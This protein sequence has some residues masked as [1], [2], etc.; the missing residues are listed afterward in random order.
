M[1]PTADATLR[2]HA[3][4]EYAD[5]L[6][7]LARLDDR[8]R[9]PRWRLSPWAVVDLP[10][11]RHAVRRHGR[12]RRS[13]SAPGGSWRSP[14]PRS[15]PTARCCCSA[16]PAPPRRG[17]P[18][19]SRRPIS[20]DSTLLVQGTAGTP[21]EA[22]RYGWNYARLLA[23]G[24]S[25]GALV[26]APGDAGDG[27]RRDRPGR[28]ADPHPVRRAG[29]ADHDPVGEDAADP[30]ARR[31]GPGACRGFN[32]IATANDRDRGVNEL[33]SALRRRFNTVVLPLPASAEEEVEIV[34][35][36]VDALGRRRS[37]CPTCRR[38]WRRS[39][40]WSRSSASCAPASPTDGRTKLK[41]PVG[42]AVHRRGDLG[43]H[44]RARAGRPLR[45]RRAAARRRRGG[46]RRR[47][48][49]GPGRRTGSSGRSTSRRSCASATAGRDLYRA[50]RDAS[51]MTRRT[52]FGD[53]PPRAR[54]ARSLRARAGASYAA[55]RGPDR[56]AARGRPAARAGRRRRTWSR[57]SRCSPTRR[58]ARAAPRSGRSPCSRPSGRRSAGR[59]SAG[60]PSRFMR[61]ARRRAS[62]P[63]TRARATSRAGG[64]RA[65]RP[66]RG[67]GRRGRV[68]RPRALVGGRRRVP[69]ATA[70]RR[71]RRSTEAMAALREDARRR[72][73][74]ARGGAARGVHAPAIRAAPQG[75][76]ERVAVVCGAWH[77]PALTGPLPPAAADDARCSRACPRRKVAA[78]WVPWTHGRLARVRATAPAI[79]SPGLVP[80]PLRPRPTSRSPRWLTAVAAA[81]ARA[82]TCRCP[83]RT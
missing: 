56:G 77:A 8:P 17:S 71:S 61:P 3:E 64:R 29:R 60:C 6:A 33:S 57:R 28:G 1:T 49:Q 14:S 38:R 65:R 66:A 81:A 68:R 20:G 39:A 9:P 23:E 50:C 75:R 69:A 18:S 41:S 82:R 70:R 4:Q 74:D 79:D 22:I 67:A 21:E 36:R 40:A 76:H 43:G 35:P 83:P 42:H 13:T 32:V 72:R 48:R 44:Q 12:S 24:P 78:T 73:T 46:H 53:P 51:R 47:G 19:T 7:A 16:C 59:S 10:A 80:P 30:R 55:R 52:V 37:S 26:P 58:R 25:R 31:R 34:A 27:D 5:E 15:P 11:R 63:G 2:P 62:W 54:S 45:R